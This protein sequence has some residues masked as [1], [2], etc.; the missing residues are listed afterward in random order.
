MVRKYTRAAS[1]AQPVEPG[2]APAAEPAPSS[3]RERI[4]DVALDLFVRKGYAETSLREIAAEL[5]VSKA[6]LYYHFESK[7]AILLALHLRLHNLGN[8]VYPLLQDR[9]QEG[10]RW[11]MLIDLLIGLALK[12]RRLL[13]LSLRNQKALADL[14]EVER[15]K[16]HGTMHP[17][18]I[19]S[20]FLELLNDPTASLEQRVRRMASLGT[21][22]G[23]L[24]AAGSFSNETDA[25]LESALRTVTADLLGT[26]SREGASRA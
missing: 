17:P 2:T 25:E 9:M 21:I 5:G 16:D 10:E 6:A 8:E 3:T 13:E 26:P 4:L 7:Q 22:A 12:N 1:T 11:D 23:V 15:L 20:R 14:H 24:L 19:E 18:D